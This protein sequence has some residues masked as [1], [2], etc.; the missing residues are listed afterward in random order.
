MRFRTGR[1]TDVKIKNRSPVR[2]LNRKQEMKN[3]S[4]QPSP[5]RRGSPKMQSNDSVTEFIKS[6]LAKDSNYS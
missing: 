6:V 5:Q 3:R 2:M 4:H 1:R